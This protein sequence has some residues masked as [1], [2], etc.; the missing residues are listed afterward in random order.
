[1]S[2]CSAVDDQFPLVFSS[3]YIFS[4]HLSHFISVLMNHPLHNLP[5]YLPFPVPQILY[6]PPRSLHLI[7]SKH[8]YFC[9]YLVALPCFL[10]STHAITP[11]ISQVLRPSSLTR[12]FELLHQK[13]SHLKETFFFSS[14]FLLSL[15]I[16]AFKASE[17]TVSITSL[18]C[19]NISFSALSKCNLVPLRIT[20][21]AA[22]KIILLIHLLDD[23]STVPAVPHQANRYSTFHFIDIWSQ[24]QELYA[25][26]SACMY[27]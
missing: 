9:N 4:L 11:G 6:I 24:M 27:H 1:M 2:L 16:H 18:I 22:T 5:M 14:L 15:E 17:Y 23:V 19:C 3:D 20:Q 25:F 21:N 8:C 7:L 10:A 13:S 26:S 12:T